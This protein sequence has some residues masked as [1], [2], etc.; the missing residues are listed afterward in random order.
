M[1]RTEASLD[2][3]DFPPAARPLV[4]DRSE[5]RTRLVTSLVLIP[6]FLVAIGVGGGV[7]LAAILFL[8]GVGTWEFLAMAAHKEFRPRRLAGLGLALALPLTFYGAVVT[9]IELTALLAL[10]VVGIAVVQLFRTGEEGAIAAVAT[11]VFGALYVGFLFGHFVLVREIPREVA[12]MPYWIGAALLAVPIALTWA[13][14]TAAYAIGRRWGSRKLMPAVSPGKSVE[15]AI[16][17]LVV[18][19]VVAIP[20][21]ALLDRWVDLFTL[22]D[23][24]ALGVLIGVAAPCGDLIESSFKRDAGVK[25]VS[26]LIPGHGG[27]LDRFDSLLVT[28]P[29]FYYYVR[30]AAL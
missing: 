25:D 19:I 8:V 22:A 29:L 24:F 28:V 17:A 30:W 4:P 9:V 13:N 1:N 12:G 10:G 5:L 18:T 2:G 26:R 15:G 20:L 3:I 16:G 14:D 21:V 6:L 11:T 27:V 23:G 7:F